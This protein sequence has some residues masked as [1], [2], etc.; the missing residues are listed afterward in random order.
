MCRQ[1]QFTL[2]IWKKN[3]TFNFHREYSTRGWQIKIVPLRYSLCKREK[4]EK[5]FDRLMKRFAQTLFRRFFTIYLLLPLLFFPMNLTQNKFQNL[6]QQQKNFPYE[7]SVH[8][9]TV[10]IKMC[11]FL[12]LRYAPIV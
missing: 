5:N 7:H 6:A 11:V 8:F 2:A 3:S 9:K 1:C 12:I 10:Q 4:K